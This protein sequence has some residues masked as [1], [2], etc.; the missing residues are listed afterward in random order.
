MN[1]PNECN[2]GTQYD[3]TGGP[4][5]A[6]CPRWE[7]VKVEEHVRLVEDVVSDL[8]SDL[9]SELAAHT[10]AE[11]STIAKALDDVA[12][13]G[14]TPVVNDD[15]VTS[16]ELLEASDNVWRCG[17]YTIFHNRYG[18]V[19]ERKRKTFHRV[20]GKNEM[21]KFSKIERWEFKTTDEAARAA[22]DMRIGK[23]KES[24]DFYV[25]KSRQ[26]DATSFMIDE[27]LLRRRL[28]H[29]LPPIGDVVTELRD[30][31]AAPVPN[32]EIL[33]DS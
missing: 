16:A 30:M 19:L 22:F 25:V 6:T 3:P 9:V 33:F 21:K 12:A 26:G 15:N 10:G 8:V 13:I 4:H 29:D 1:D 5:A 31:L 2:C 17:C 28:E 18:V 32:F 11:P 23:G 27:S 14:P 7:A 24:F 20:A